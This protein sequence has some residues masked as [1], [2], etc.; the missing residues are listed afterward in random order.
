MGRLKALWIT[1]TFTLC[2]VGDT[3][4]SGDRGDISLQ[5]SKDS[6]ESHREARTETGTWSRKPPL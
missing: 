5:C 4:G 1:L 3:K 2:K 6:A